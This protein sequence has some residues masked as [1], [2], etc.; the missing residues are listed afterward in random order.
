M[1]R[2]VPGPRDGRSVPRRQGVARLLLVAWIYNTQSA[3]SA[4]E[5]VEIHWVGLS[6]LEASERAAIEAR[7]RSL[8][9]G[10]SDLINLRIT[11]SRTHHHKHGGTE[12]SIT[13][14]ARGREVVAGRERPDLRQALDEVLDAFE[15]E[16][17]RMR[18]K[19]R[20]LS[21]MQPPE[22][23][24]LGVVDKIFRDEGYG[25]I[26]TEGGEQVYFHRNAVKEGL[27]FDRLAEADRVALDVEA[28]RDGPQATTVV[29]PPPQP[30]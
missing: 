20:D 19:R 28:G 14:Q 27:D 29:A 30:A 17:H 6:G 11:G 13:C 24:Y 5:N 3:T 25:F 26:L 2:H 8:A 7:L 4:E 15:R 23:P 1:G 9:E 10:H 12:V 21:R 22:P 18:D 16:V